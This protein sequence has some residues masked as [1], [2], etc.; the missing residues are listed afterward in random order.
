MGKIVLESCHLTSIK[1]RGDVTA[2]KPPK[3]DYF[4]TMT[5]KENPK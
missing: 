5:I 2:D 3:S 1:A 4:V